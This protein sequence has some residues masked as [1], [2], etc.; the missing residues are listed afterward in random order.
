[1]QE[2]LL[3]ITTGLSDTILFTR[4]ISKSNWGCEDKMWRT[5]NV[6]GW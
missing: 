4:S 5:E 3:K 6:L 1:M 2:L